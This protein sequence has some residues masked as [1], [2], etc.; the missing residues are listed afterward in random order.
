MIFSDIL[1]YLRNELI[2]LNKEANVIFFWL[3]QADIRDQQSTLNMQLNKDNPYSYMQQLVQCMIDSINLSWERGPKKVSIQDLISL[4]N[5]IHYIERQIQDLEAKSTDTVSEQQQEV[6]GQN[7]P[8]NVQNQI[9]EVERKIKDL[10][11]D[12]VVEPH[13]GVSKV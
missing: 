3:Q 9:Q 12:T 2:R 1:A 5:Q 8:Q 7:Q 13:Q 6:S 11:I 4:Q 10:D